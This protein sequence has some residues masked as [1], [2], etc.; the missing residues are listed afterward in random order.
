VTCRNLQRH[1]AV[2]PLLALLLQPGA[3]FGCAACF[4]QSGSPLA[5]GMNWGIMVLLGFISCVLLGVTAFFIYIVR[6][7]NTLAAQPELISTETKQ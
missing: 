6:R 3:A 1:L 4:G 2:L 5:Q 7:A